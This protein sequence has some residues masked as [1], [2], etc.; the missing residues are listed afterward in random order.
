MIIK[1]SII[2]RFQI[3][4]RAIK[5][6]VFTTQSKQRLTY[7]KPLRTPLSVNK[8]TA[9]GAGKRLYLAAVCI[10]VSFASDWLRVS[11][12]FWTKHRAK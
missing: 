5:T 10:L 12:V 2:D 3:E 7:K 1:L 9:F 4:N 11:K 6:K 8:L